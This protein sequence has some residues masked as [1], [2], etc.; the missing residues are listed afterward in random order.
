MLFRSNVLGEMQMGVLLQKHNGPSAAAGWDGDHYAVFEGPEG[1]LGLVWLTTWD[2][3]D[4]AGEFTKAYVHYQTARLG[5]I[6]KPPR[7]ILDTLWRNVGER[8][9]LVQRRGLDV[10]VIEGFAPDATVGLL[11]S[12]FHAKKVEMK[13]DKPPIASEKAKNA[14]GEK[15]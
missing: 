1:R 14:P 8:L 12:A 5:D 10:A 13:P 2:S 3:E 9:Y 7:E 11:E 6:S 15:S 4:D